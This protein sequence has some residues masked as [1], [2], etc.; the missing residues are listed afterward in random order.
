MTSQGSSINNRNITVGHFPT[1]RFRALGKRANLSCFAFA[2]TVLRQAKCCTPWHDNK[3]VNFEDPTQ[4]LSIN[5]I[6]AVR[7]MHCF[8]NNLKRVRCVKCNCETVALENM[9]EI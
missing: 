8:S 3:N 1:K 5:Y 4:P 6:T 2:N 9:R 7:N